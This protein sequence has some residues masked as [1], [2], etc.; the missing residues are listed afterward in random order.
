MPEETGY[1]QNKFLTEEKLN[2]L[3]MW[4]SFHWM[5]EEA[6]SRGDW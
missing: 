1:L 5:I 6:E 3:I 2:K 4:H